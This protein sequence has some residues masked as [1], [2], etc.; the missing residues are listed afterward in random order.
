M[1]HRRT[2]WERLRGLVQRARHIRGRL[3][4][5]ELEEL[6]LL[7][8][9][10]M[11]DVSAAQRD[12]PNDPTTA[13]VGS[14]VGQ[15]HGLIY[16]EP[17]VSL[18]KIRRFFWQDVP[19]EYRAAWRFL[20]TSAALLFGPW[21]A[22]MLAIIIDRSVAELMVPQNM[23][24]GMKQG[25]TWFDIESSRRVAVSAFIMTHNAQIGL[26]AYAG[27]MLAGVGT[28]LLL[29]FNGLS[30]GAVF[31]ALVA[32]GLSDRMIGF[33]APH[34][35]LELSAVVVCGAGGLMLAQALLWPGFEPR[36]VVL[37]A[38]A[39]RSARLLLGTLPFFAIAGLIEGNISPMAFAWPYKLAIGLATFVVYLSYVSGK[40]T[41]VRL[42]LPHRMATSTQ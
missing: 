8:R 3:S 10:T 14:L 41:A 6:S 21:L 17:P 18:A 25:E 16:V 32:Y 5:D 9:Q 28:V 37:G 38:A 40:L 31:G 19:R 34:G 12:F 24:A 42:R 23:L 35:F 29:L 33:V 15:A 4:V 2:R 7:Y 22:I 20:A 30:L 26:A 13:Y 39:R 11:N 1:A 36:S 27:G